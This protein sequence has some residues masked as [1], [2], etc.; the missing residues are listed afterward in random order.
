MELQSVVA[1]AV[2]GTGVLFGTGILKPTKIETFS[3]QSPQYAVAA[4]FQSQPSYQQQAS[5]FAAVDEVYV[6][7]ANRTVSA[8]RNGNLIKTYPIGIGE[9]S[10][11]TP[12]GTFSVL[13]KEADP[14]YYTSGGQEIP[15]GSNNPLGSRWIGFL[16]AGDEDWGF[17]GGNINTESRG[18][19][20]MLEADLQE[21]YEMVAVG[22]KISIR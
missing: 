20:H 1:I 3:Y 11:P 7:L 17:H 12:Q 18:C 5:T 15:P 16:R 10:T 21:F 9:P 4:Q 6:S 14:F 8:Y 19:I 13:E 2:A 22:T